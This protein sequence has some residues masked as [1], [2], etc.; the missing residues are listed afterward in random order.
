[1]KSHKTILVVEDS[2]TQR[3]LMTNCLKSVGLDA[4]GAANGEQALQEFQRYRPCLVLLDVVMPRMNGYEV[5]RQLK[6]SPEDKPVVVMC[7]IKGE[8]CDRYWA[9]QQG[10]DGYLVKPI[11]P[12]QLIDTVREF[13]KDEVDPLNF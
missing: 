4:I 1:M 7:T 6:R 2:Q 10:A 8:E 12:Q 13:L 3:T 11:R 5:L 9:N